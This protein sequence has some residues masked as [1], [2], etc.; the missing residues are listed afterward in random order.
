MRRGGT[1][2]TLAIRYC[3]SLNRI[4]PGWHTELTSTAIAGR[5]GMPDPAA[6][7]KFFRR[8]TGETPATFRILGV[9]K[10]TYDQ[11]TAYFRGRGDRI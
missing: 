6:F 3:D 9:H 8:E 7:G 10:N 4:S 11:F 2:I 5:V 1:S